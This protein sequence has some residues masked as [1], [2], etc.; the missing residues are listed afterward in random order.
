MK[1]DQ[2]LSSY[3]SECETFSVLVKKT[4]D[5]KQIVYGEVYIPNVVDTHGEMMLPGDVE[6]MA[7]R[8]MSTMKN[9]QIDISHDNEVIKAVTVESWIAKA[10]DPLW[11]E[12]A[13]VMGLLIED[14]EKW[15]DVKSGKLNGF[16]VETWISKT[17]A[18]VELSYYPHVF[19]ITEKADG[20]EHVFF[21]QIDDQG[22]VVG[23]YTSEDEDHSHV[24]EFATATEMTDKHA[25]R[26]SLP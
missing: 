8:W 5:E 13:W 2:L 1:L 20:H 7:H 14:T 24:I 15:A 10:D 17:D 11:H 16:S 4:N 21:I 25:H 19:G 26:F 3:D 18:V 6:L 12:G 23:G 22:V 9:N